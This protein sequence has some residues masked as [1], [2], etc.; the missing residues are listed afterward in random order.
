MHYMTWYTDTC[1]ITAMGLLYRLCDMFK[2]M[3]Y[4]GLGSIGCFMVRVAL[5]GSHYRMD[6]FSSV[7][8]NAN[9]AEKR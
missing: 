7:G 4:V 9:P 6:L 5:M 1:G 8:D 3:C 2:C